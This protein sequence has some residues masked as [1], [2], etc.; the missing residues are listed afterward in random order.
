MEILV[1]ILYVVVRVDRR[2]HVPD[3]SK[4]PG[5]YSGT[6]A[7]GSKDSQM[8]D[9]EQAMRITSE[10]ETFDD[11]PKPQEKEKSGTMNGHGQV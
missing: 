3:G 7:L 5:D 11:A 9:G 1:V 4:G 2:F 6:R 8:E 10:E